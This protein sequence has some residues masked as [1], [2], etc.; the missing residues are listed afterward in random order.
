MYQ[1]FGTY[2]SSLTMPAITRLLIAWTGTPTLVLLAAVVIVGVVLPLVWSLWRPLW[3]DVVAHR[4]PL[5]GPMWLWAST[6]DLCHV[7]ALLLEAGLP[8][9]QALR[10][11]AAGLRSSELAQACRRMARRVE[12]GQ[13]LAEAV[14]VTAPIPDT[15]GPVVQWGESRSALPQALQAA[16]EMYEGRVRM[17][18]SFV[19]LFLPPGRVSVC[20]RRDPALD[21]GHFSAD[22]QTSRSTDLRARFDMAPEVAPFSPLMTLV[23]LAV[24]LAV[25][26]VYGEARLGGGDFV[27]LVMRVIGWVLVAMGLLAFLEIVLSIIFGILFWIILMIALGTMVARY[28]QA[29]RNALLW[30]LAIAAERQMPLVPAVE[31]FAHEWGGPFGR[32]T[33]RLSGALRSGVQLPDALDRI[34]GLAPESGRIAARVGTEAGCLGPALREAAAGRVAHEPI[35]QGIVSKTYYLASVLLVA[36]LVTVFMAIAVAPKMVRII[37]DFGFETPWISQQVLKGI[38]NPTLIGWLIIRAR[39]P[40]SVDG[41][42]PAAR[43]G[44]ASLERS[45]SGSLDQGD[46]H[47]PGRCGAWPGSSSAASRCTRPWR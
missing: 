20:R 18:L 35:W 23:G 24:L 14:A 11:T 19:R 42:F 43:F 40:G 33:L 46:R 27:H 41:V 44:L 25:R 31:A 12:A 16:A 10:S 39:R 22:V 17:Q 26:V 30:V 47:Q 36:Q 6:V 38:E 3:L 15:L 37:A 32:R 45:V 5:V 28:R 4:L 34:R 9:P 13:P 8:L 2:Q 21:A 1:D 7:L 29:E